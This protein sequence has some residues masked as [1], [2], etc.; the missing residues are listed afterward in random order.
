MKTSRSKWKA[1]MAALISRRAERS[2]TNTHPAVNKV[3]D[4]RSHLSKVHIGK[5]LVDVGCG[6]MSI[7]SMLPPG[8]EYIGI[9]AFPYN[10]Q[11]M[12]MEIEHCT[13]KDNEFETLICF[14][15]LDG[16]HNLD[17]SLFHMKRICSNNIVLLTGINIEPD[18]FH[19]FMITEH[20]LE[21][22]FKDWNV[23]FKEWMNDRVILIEYSK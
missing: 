8:T 14:A 21:Q 12:H 22:Q 7:K 23:T 15:V 18:E 17:R 16:L 5:T 4:C 11:V 9:D 13:F 3:S 6:S 2:A 1:A 10:D 20:Y 19:T